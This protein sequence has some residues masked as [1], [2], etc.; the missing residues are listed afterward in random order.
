MQFCDTAQR[1]KAAAKVAR[2]SKSAGH[3]TSTALPT[4]K[5]ATQQVWKPA[6]QPFRA[7]PGNRRG[8]RRFREIL[9]DWKSRYRLAGESVVYPAVRPGIGRMVGEFLSARP[10]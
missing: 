2:I 7:R 6:Q 9:I 1:G 8:L 4:W 3:P 10:P 5:S